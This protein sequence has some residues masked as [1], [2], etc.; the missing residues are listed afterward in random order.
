MPGDRLGRGLNAV[1]DDDVAVRP[2]EQFEKRGLAS[3]LA[4]LG[5]DHL[6]AGEVDA[7]GYCPT[8]DANRPCGHDTAFHLDQVGQRDAAG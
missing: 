1:G 7:P 3:E 4:D 6:S 5:V 2:A 8:V